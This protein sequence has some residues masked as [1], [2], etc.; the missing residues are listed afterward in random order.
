MT[1]ATA[2][3]GS[4]GAMTSTKPHITRIDVAMAAVASAFALWEG[5]LNVTENAVSAPPISVPLFLGLSVPLLWR[6][7]APVAALTATLVALLASVALYGDSLVRCGVVVPFALILGFAAGARRPRGPAL[8][9]LALAQALVLVACLTDAPSGAPPEAM[10]FCGPLV[11]AAWAGGRLMRSRGRMV[12]ELEAQTRELRRVRDERARLEVSADRARLSSELDVLLQRRLGELARLAGEGTRGVE[13]A[14]TLARIEDEGRSTLDEM[15]ALVGVLR[16]DEAPTEPAPALTHLEALLVHAKGTGARLVVDGSPRALPAGV[17]LSA[18]RVVEHLLEAVQDAPGVEVA[19]RF[20]DD[21]LEVR[22]AGPQRRHAER[23]IERA[24]ERV[25][26]H[27]GTLQ[28]TTRSGRTEALV[29][30]PIYA[31]V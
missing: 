7:A 5:I 30:L 15:R 8:L 9:G 2:D 21:A 28:A 23:A 11:L 26:L 4:L 14:S 20:G 24:R 3:R 22:V 19:V 18:Y 10:L 31:A 27:E 6:R 29:S 12:G 17:E 16:D 13:A 25:R 1:T